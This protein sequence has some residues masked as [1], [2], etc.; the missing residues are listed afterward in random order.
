MFLFF[1][2][3]FCETS[4]SGERACKRE[5]EV[6]VRSETT[7]GLVVDL[8]H[9]DGLVGVGLGSKTPSFSLSLFVPPYPGSMQ[10]L[11]DT[12]SL[13]AGKNKKPAVAYST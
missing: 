3:G 2:S 5:R 9:R 4:P 6:D 1:A 10:V 11:W 8:P 12:M 7:R 13:P